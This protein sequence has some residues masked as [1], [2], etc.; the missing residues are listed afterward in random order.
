M[1][2]SLSESSYLA[3]NKGACQLNCGAAEILFRIRN[4]NEQCNIE[5]WVLCEAAFA[6]RLVIAWGSAKFSPDG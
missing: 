6:G 5:S 4:K 1:A 2:G 3:E